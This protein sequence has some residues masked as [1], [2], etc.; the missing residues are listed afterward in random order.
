MAKN[1]EFMY[2][3]SSNKQKY[4][5]CVKTTGISRSLGFWSFG[6]PRIHEKSSD[7]WDGDLIVL[8][9]SL[10][11]S[12][13]NSLIVDIV[14]PNP[15]TIIGASS[16]FG[17]PWVPN[18]VFYLQARIGLRDQTNQRSP[19]AQPDSTMLTPL[20]PQHIPNNFHQKMFGLIRIPLIS[21]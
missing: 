9:F 5:S 18:C 15:S 20:Y 14:S 7:H 10:W 4:V 2:Q 11:F 19:S 1:P 21:R 12:P 17:Q 6:I 3:V 13:W 16:M 8:C